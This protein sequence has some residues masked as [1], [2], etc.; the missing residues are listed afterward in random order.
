VLVIFWFVVFSD[1][2]GVVIGDVLAGTEPILLSDVFVPCG[3]E[4]GGLGGGE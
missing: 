2:A 4:C 3:D 1:D